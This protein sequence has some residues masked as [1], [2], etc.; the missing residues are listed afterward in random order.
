[1]AKPKQP[2]PMDLAQSQTAINRDSAIQGQL[3]NNMNETNP[4]GSVNY[5][6]SGSQTYTDAF[7]N[8][9]TIP[10]FD[11]NV[12]LDPGQ[13][14]LLNRQV[15]LG[16]SVNDLAMNQVGQLNTMPVVGDYS[17]DRSAVTDALIG[18]M[19]PYWNQDE[20]A[21]RSQ[22]ANQGLTPGSEAYQRELGMLSRQ[23]NDARLG[24]V[25]AGGQEQSRL[26]GLNLAQRSQLAGE[27]GGLS[28]IASPTLPQFQGAFQQGVSSVPYDQYVYQDYQNQVDQRNNR[29]QGLFGLAGTVAT[30]LFGL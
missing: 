19:E 4:L 13:Q 6:Q 10:T 28:A 27:I 18:R 21:A 8:E 25:L 20:Q 30:G 3:I 26:A 1:M 14:D 9:V 5:S 17:A 16:R 24:A 15:A 29:L 7:G 11:R 12:T 2:D 23:K 22:L